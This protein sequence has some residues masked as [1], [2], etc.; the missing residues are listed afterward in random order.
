LRCDGNS[1]VASASSAFSSSSSST[2]IIFSL[3]RATDDSIVR[4]SC[5]H[6]ETRPIRWYVAITTEKADETTVYQMYVSKK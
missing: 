2:L 6:V 1:S 5:D 4:T 3:K